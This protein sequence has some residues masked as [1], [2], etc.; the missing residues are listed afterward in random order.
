MVTDEASPQGTN[1]LRS[2]APAFAISALLAASIWAAVFWAMPPI[3]G[4]ADPL[5]RL[6]FSL[7]CICLATLLAFL[8][9]LEAV[10]HERLVSP[11]FDPLL[12][13]ETRRLK[14]NLRYLQNTL[15]QW[16]LFV[17]GLLALAVYC[18]TGQSMRAVIA[19]SIVWTLA[20]IIFWVGYHQGAQ[21]RIA[22]L[23]GTAQSMLIL[24]YVSALFG[25]EVAG[26]VGA[27]VPLILFALAEMVII[28]TTMRA[29]AP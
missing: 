29:S 1:R 5:A 6:I 28:R 22:G 16:V 25:H 23:V 19:A 21:H 27:V 17:P 13:A 15:E 18:D 10:S 12:G 9:G 2:A 7:K 14:I 4:M 8:T 26:R 20:R 11:A 3:E 24:L